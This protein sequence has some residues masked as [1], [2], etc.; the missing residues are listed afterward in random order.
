LPPSDGHIRKKAGRNCE[1]AGRLPDGR[2][3]GRNALK[4]EGKGQLTKN[5]PCVAHGNMEGC[6]VRMLYGRILETGGLIFNPD[7]P[8]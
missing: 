1:G 3:S 6:C 8:N 5:I 7:F 2:G 4:A